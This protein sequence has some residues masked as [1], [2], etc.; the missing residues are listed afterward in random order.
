VEDDTHPRKHPIRFAM[1]QMH[2]NEVRTDEGLVRR[3]LAAQ[4]P[5]LA[6]LPIRQVPSAGTD[7]AIYR[8]GH[9]LAV[10]LPRIDW[11][12]GQ[13]EKEHEWLPKLASLLPLPLPIPLEMGKPGEGYPWRWSIYRWIEGKN[14]TAGRLPD[15]AGAAR[16]LADFIRALQAVDP[17]GGPAALEHNLRGVPLHFRDEATRKAIRE[18]DGAID[19]IAAFRLWDSALNAGGWERPPCWFHGDLLAGNILFNKG[20]ISAVIDFAG[21]GVGDPACDLMPAWSLFEGESRRVFR[22]RLAVDEATWLRGRGHAL[23]Q[24][25]IFI[26]YYQHTNPIGVRNARRQLDAVLQD[27]ASRA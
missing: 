26:P 18:M 5:H 16:D 12:L 9:E 17:Q 11:A 14:L 3:L 8:L 1:T 20:R 2:Q 23:S 4:F 6:H 22:D 27:Q 7:N 24:A 10:R 15:P 19:S 25:V 13:V 21:L